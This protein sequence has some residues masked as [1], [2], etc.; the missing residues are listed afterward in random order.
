MC[1][2]GEQTSLAGIESLLIRINSMTIPPGKRSNKPSALTFLIRTCAH[3]FTKS[4]SAS[5]VMRVEEKCTCQHL[6]GSD[7]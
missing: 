5:L 2:R 3:L 4:S 7:A 6:H 1:R